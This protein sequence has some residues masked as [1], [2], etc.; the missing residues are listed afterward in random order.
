M[1]EINKELSKQ[2]IKDK[3]SL[4]LENKTLIKKNKEL[5]L[6]INKL[7]L[8]DFTEIDTK[9]ENALNIKNEMLIS[10]IDKEKLLNA[11]KQKGIKNSYFWDILSKEI[12]KEQEKK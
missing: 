11:L 4:F 12:A 5:N 1:I 10:G 9:F 2:S 6:E 8:P 7:K 3:F